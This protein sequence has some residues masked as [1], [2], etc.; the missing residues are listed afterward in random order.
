MKILIQAFFFRKASR[1]QN[2][3]KSR[4]WLVENVWELETIVQ[5][6]ECKRAPSTPQPPEQTEMGS[7][8]KSVYVMND[9]GLIEKF[10]FITNTP[11]S[12]HTPGI[13]IAM[14]IF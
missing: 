9:V 1:V 13:F 14:G 8:I 12:P 4:L 11:D 5:K 10:Y 7:I 2:F 3:I 6:Y